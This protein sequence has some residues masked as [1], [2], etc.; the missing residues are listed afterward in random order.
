MRRVSF[1]V[2]CLVDIQCAKSPSGPHMNCPSCQTSD[3]LGGYHGPHYDRSTYRAVGGKIMIFQT[4]DESLLDDT[5]RH[6]LEHG[7]GCEEPSNCGNGG[8]ACRATFESELR[9]YLCSEKGSQRPCDVESSNFTPSNCLKWVFDVTFSEHGRCPR[10][11]S[12]CR[13]PSTGGPS[14]RCFG[15]LL[16]T[17]AREMEREASSCIFN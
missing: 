12:T 6:E 4:S 10:C 11:V 3:P 13:D 1:R 17:T 9:A 7:R 15:R 16:D 14:R 5:I 8:R 2:P